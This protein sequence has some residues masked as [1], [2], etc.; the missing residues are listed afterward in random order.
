MKKIFKWTL[1]TIMGCGILFTA[2]GQE[3][4]SKK[5]L[6]KVNAQNLNV[7]VKPGRNYTSVGYINRG[8]EVEIIR[9]SGDWFEI[10]APPK[11]A[12][13]VPSDA[14]KDGKTIKATTL[15]GGPG[16]EHQSY[17]QIQPGREIKVIDSRRKLWLKIEPLSELT[18]WVY[19]KYIKVNPA[20]A[21][22]IPGLKATISTIGKTPQ[23]TTEE[24]PLDLPF[25]P[26][27]EKSVTMS[28]VI[29]PVSAGTVVT[30]ALCKSFTEHSALA[31]I[32]SQKV[33]LKKYSAQK[34]KIEGKSRLVSNWS[35]PVV[36]VEKVTII[37]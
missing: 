6:G 23:P 25:V 15:R 28:G 4:S 33:D 21:S 31:Y 8:D 24:K 5:I 37:K 12:V 2:S 26:G 22:K 17:L 13:W 10:K 7:R 35:V 1:L 9:A 19:K 14:V 18:A 3:K 32:T 20:D 30:H 27:S 29:Q 16:V 34:V 11:S 36:E